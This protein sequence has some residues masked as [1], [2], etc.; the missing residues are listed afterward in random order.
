MS[1]AFSTN[2]TS[3]KQTAVLLQSECRK[4]I[5]RF[6][7]QNPA[8]A[9]VGPMCRNSACHWWYIILT[10]WY[11]THSNNYMAEDV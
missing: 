9:C 3:N 2:T 5:S 4:E 11:R 10:I 7:K 1:A 6:P 8:N